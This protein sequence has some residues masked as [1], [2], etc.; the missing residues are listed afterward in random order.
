MRYRE[1]WE[2]IYG[3][4]RET[5]ERVRELVEAL[6]EQIRDEHGERIEQVARELGF[7]YELTVEHSDENPAMCVPVLRVYKDDLDIWEVLSRLEDLVTEARL[8]VK[9]VPESALNR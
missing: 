4:I 2:R 3:L 7:I 5:N 1:Y 6:V 8:V 9:K